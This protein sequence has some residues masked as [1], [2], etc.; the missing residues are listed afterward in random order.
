MLLLLALSAVVGF[1]GG[2]LLSGEAVGGP[3]V[4]FAVESS[5]RKRPDA[6]F[7]REG[8][9]ACGGGAKVA[10]DPC[11][12][13]CDGIEP[14]AGVARVRCLPVGAQLGVDDLVELRACLFGAVVRRVGVAFGVADLVGVRVGVGDRA[15]D[16]GVDRVFDAAS[17]QPHHL[18]C[19]LRG[20]GGQVGE[21]GVPALG[22]RGQLGAGL[23]DLSPVLA[24]SPGAVTDDLGGSPR[25]CQ[26]LVPGAPD[27]R[28]EV[29]RSRT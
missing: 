10:L 7:A 16:V 27:P 12:F 26:F 14:A 24:Q 18:V 15:G 11:Q 19:E 6:R 8:P 4:V 20:A 22:E 23:A 1:P 13:V 5:V 17:V 28:L 21:G 3:P 2:R 29:G 25:L 9:D